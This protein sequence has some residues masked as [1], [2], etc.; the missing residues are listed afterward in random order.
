MNIT[1]NTVNQT[2]KSN[3]NTVISFTENFNTAKGLRFP[4][5]CLWVIIP[6]VYCFFL[7]AFNKK[8]SSGFYLP[9]LKD[10]NY[11]LSMYCIDWLQSKGENN[12]NCLSNRPPQANNLCNCV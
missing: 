12:I 10:T 11:F 3:S 4:T 8:E 1:P 9:H 2:N 7:A 5:V 6:K